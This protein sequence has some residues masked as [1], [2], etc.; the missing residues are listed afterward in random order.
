MT[1]SQVPVVLPR[2]RT[3]F[4]APAWPAAAP[5]SCVPPSVPT[6]AFDPD[7]RRSL[8]SAQVASAA[9]EVPHVAERDLG[10]VRVVAHVLPGADRQDLPQD[11][12]RREEGAVELA[13]HRHQLVV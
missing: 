10:R 4:A 5:R 11:E 2:A 13:R 12:A 3:K 1:P 8:G 6:Y 9:V 7:P